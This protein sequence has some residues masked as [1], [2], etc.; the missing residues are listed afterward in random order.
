MQK[1]KNKKNRKVYF[2]V[3]GVALVLAASCSPKKL[4]VIPDSITSDN[5]EAQ[6][7]FNEA[8]QILEG[9]QIDEADKKLDLFIR[10][11]PK[12]PLRR[13]AELFRGKIAL[14]KGDPLGARLILEPLMKGR[15]S[16]ADRAAFYDGL[17][18]F[19]LGEYEKSL[20]RLTPYVD[21]LADPQEKRLLLDALWRAAK[22]TN[23]ISDALIW[24][25]EYLMILP[26]TEKDQRLVA[27]L[28][29]LSQMVGDVKV[30]QKIQDK[31]NPQGAAWPIVVARMARIYL[32]Q[33]ELP[34]ANAAIE[35]A[36]AENR[37]EEP[38]IREVVTIIENKAEIALGHVG[39]IAPLSGRS[40]LIGETVINGV[41]LAAKTMSTDADIEMTV[42]IRDSKG[43]PDLASHA[44][45][46]L[47]KNEHVSAIIGPL[48]GEGAAAA[49]E[50]AE[51]LGVPLI[52]L[53]VRE[54][55]PK[56]RPHVFR[57][58]TS[59][60]REIAALVETASREG[61]TRFAVLHPNNGYGN[62][63]AAIFE[64]TVKAKGHQF[65]GAIGYPPET[66][67]FTNEIERLKGF[68]SFDTLF[69][70]DSANRLA[71]VAPALAAAGLWSTPAGSAPQGP[72][73]PV[74][75]LVPST[76]F[77]EDLI[78]RAVRYLD[79]AL[80]TTFFH[81]NASAG[82]AEFTE[83]YRTEY[84]K[85]PNYIAGF[86]HDALV[87]IA[88]A[89]RNGAKDRSD[90]KNWL[91]QDFSNSGEGSYLAT[92]FSGFSEEGEPLANPRILQILDR[93]F[94]VLK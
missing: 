28:Q 47:F 64:R 34:K 21:R 41:R 90:I 10:H 70:P 26:A 65:R 89:I 35:R 71:L 69:L 3:G 13:Y 14:E 31:L 84:G 7:A 56:G 54:D 83:R 77:S 27:E 60:S 49:G 81:P 68:G 74:Q 91:S 19:R 88:N 42:T 23:R 16:I 4:P 92:P 32:A 93:Q 44:V 73:Q 36:Q 2:V 46:E 1:T 82:A 66:K 62:T 57:Q 20:G 22:Q 33:G 8:R 80:F 78:R 63:M 67:T 25:D 48:S 43:D 61:Q 24:L 6:Q 94:Q 51:A 85:L 76:G 45:D 9:G 15:D 72:G 37:Q 12:D 87:L 58:F 17:A 18:L 75:L 55:L 86:S 53:T 52:T 40:R 38:P 50:R 79:G 39:V 30:L 29:T 11:Y 59:N 5:P